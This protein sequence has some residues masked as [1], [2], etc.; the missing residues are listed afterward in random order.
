VG[1]VD[2]T[3]A[4]LADYELTVTEDGRLLVR[5]RP[6]EALAAAIRA[7]RDQV[8]SQVALAVLWA[9]R[10]TDR[11]YAGSYE[12]AA[13]AWWEMRAAVP[14]AVQRLVARRLPADPELRQGLQEAWQALLRPL[15][16]EETAEFLATRCVRDERCWVELD[17][18]LGAYQA[19]GGTLVDPAAAE[20]TFLVAAGDGVGVRDGL[21][22]RLLV[23]LG[24]AEDWGGQQPGARNERPHPPGVDPPA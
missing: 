10:V 20:Q 4:A 1:A 3:L 15:C 13:D 8:V 9:G 6:P 22:G 2:A 5:P 23:G 7:Q 14:L 19:W 24:L 16:L 21:S 12:A 18:L 11:L 17:W